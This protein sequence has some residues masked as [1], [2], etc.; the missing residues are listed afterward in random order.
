MAWMSFC[1]LRKK[2]GAQAYRPCGRVAEKKLS[3]RFSTKM[4][5]GRGAE[6]PLCSEETGPWVPFA[7]KELYFAGANLQGKKGGRQSDERRKRGRLAWGYAPSLFDAAE[8][9]DCGQ[10]FRWAEL[11]GRRGPACGRAWPLENTCGW[12]SGASR[13]G[14]TAPQRTTS[15]PGGAYFDFGRGLR[16][17]REALAAMSPALAEAALPRASASCARSPG[18]P[19]APSSSPE[20]PHSP[21]QGDYRVAVPAAGAEIPGTGW[22]AFP[23]GERL[24]ACSLRT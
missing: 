18:R 23:T 19:C 14:C 6:P 2:A 9:L 1:Y 20:Q 15:I 10:A 5:C 7:C 3:N 21:H 4:S 13:C 17:K 24:A 16:P 11:P 12:N 8:T 22:H